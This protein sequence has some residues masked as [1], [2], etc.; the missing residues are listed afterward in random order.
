MDGN[1]N[2]EFA[3]RDGRAAHNPQMMANSWKVI[4]YSAKMAI[5]IKQ[6]KM[7]N[8]GSNPYKVQGVP[9][10]RYQLVRQNHSF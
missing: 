7:H 3:F 9:K 8:F 4:K 2:N 10:K 1:P 5:F 6:Y